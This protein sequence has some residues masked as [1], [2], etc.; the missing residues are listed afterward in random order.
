MWDSNGTAEVGKA[1][2]K[3]VVMHHPG[4]CN[5]NCPVLKT[6]KKRD[7]QYKD[8]WTATE[9]NATQ[10]T[11]L[12]AVDVFWSLDASLTYYYKFPNVK[13]INHYDGAVYLCNKLS[14]G[15]CLDRCPESASYFWPRQ[16]SLG[17]QKSFNAFLQD[18]DATWYDAQAFTA[19][20]GVANRKRK[21]DCLGDG[22]QNGLA[23]GD[24][25]ENPQEACRGRANAWVIKG[26]SG[27]YMG[28]NGLSVSVYTSLMPIMIEC[29]SYN[30]E[31]VVQKYLEQPLLVPEAIGRP[32][33]NKIELR[34]W[35][36]MLDTNPM[37]V[38]AYGEPYFRI[39]TRPYKFVDSTVQDEYA[40]KTNCR[41]R[42]NRYSF[43][44][45]L[46]TAGTEFEQ[47]WTNRTWPMLLDAA[48]AAIIATA[49]LSFGPVVYG[50][51]RKQPKAFEVFGFDFAL[52]SEYRPW[53]LEVNKCPSM[54]EDCKKPELSKWAEDASDAMLQ[55]SIAYHEGNFTVPTPEEISLLDAPESSNLERLFP[56]SFLEESCEDTPAQSMSYGREALKVPPSLISGLPLDGPSKN[57]LLVLRTD[58]R[59]VEKMQ[60]RSSKVWEQWHAEY[61]RFKGC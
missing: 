28:N 53:L 54:L 60:E 59:D 61:P 39:A 47:A 46:Q 36:L 27:G 35:V 49:D 20:Q 43:A 22:S 25:P 57:W 24:A 18:F 11:F 38:F 13:L 7:W 23:N 45:V 16:Y 55:L 19:K 50:Q 2:G 40:H 48:R 37:I 10:D 15:W 1:T 32:A 9:W 41:D 17:K 52:D 3:K 26:I 29:Q 21:F 12:G 31:C 58:E 14:I 30:W 56:E 5:W 44:H 33:T 8:W 51:P 42:D 4:K 6:I 34:L